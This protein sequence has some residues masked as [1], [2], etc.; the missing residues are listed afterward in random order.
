MGLVKVYISFQQEKN[1][2]RGDYPLCP[3]LAVP[4]SDILAIIS[5][6]SAV[7]LLGQSKN[8]LSSL[9]NFLCPGVYIIGLVKLVISNYDGTYIKSI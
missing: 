2:L 3:K 7:D 6:F 4:H 1:I 9:I 8:K 5:S